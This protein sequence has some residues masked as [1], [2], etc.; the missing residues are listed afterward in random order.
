MYCE[1]KIKILSCKTTILLLYFIYYY[2]IITRDVRNIFK[3][4]NSLKLNLLFIQLQVKYSFSQRMLARMKNEEVIIV[5][6]LLLWFR[7]EN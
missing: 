1:K 7:T 4:F 2:L 6:L 3:I 5:V